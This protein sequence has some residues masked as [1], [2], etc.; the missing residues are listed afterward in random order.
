MSTAIYDTAWASMVSKDVNGR[1]HW[2]FPESFQII[3]DTQLPEGGWEQYRSEVDGILNT[4]AALLALLWHRKEVSYLGCPALPQDIH[5]RITKAKAWLDHILQRWDVEACDHVAFEILIP[6][7][8]ELLKQ[9]NVHLSFPGAV[10]LAMLNQKKLAKFDPQM[11][12]TPVH[13]TLIHSLEG[14]IG[15]VDFDKVR[16]H[17]TNGSMMASPSS[18]AAYL[19]YTS[20]WDDEAEAYLRNTMQECQGHGSGAVPCAFPSTIFELSWV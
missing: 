2:L 1:R 8:L 11:L 5:T 17:K 7:L 12:Y 10:P 13:T 6:A 4:A 19:I 16:H 18:T 3:L 15:K 14:F 9:E 20:D